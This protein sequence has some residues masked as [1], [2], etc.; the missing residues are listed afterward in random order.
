[1]LIDERDIRRLIPHARRMCLID[2]VL[3]W[4]DEAIVCTTGTHRDPSHPLGRDG[5]LAAI[6]A[7][8]YGAQ[9]AAIH[10]ALLARAAG[11]PPV[12]GYLGTL[13]HAR[14]AVV[15]LDTIADDRKVS[16]QVLFG[17][18]GNAI[19]ACQVDAA[20]ARIAEARI[21]IIERPIREPCA[22]A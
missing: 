22:D 4:D 19:Y 7:F 20:N 16:A 6:H 1:M 8:E 11:R 9:A 3:A 10:G 17:D 5:R 21:T 18:H 12:A 2:G 13:R 15:R 14:L